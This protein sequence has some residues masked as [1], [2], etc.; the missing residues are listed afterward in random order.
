MLVS[1]EGRRVADTRCGPDSPAQHGTLPHHPAIT[2]LAEKLALG[3]RLWGWGNHT[4]TLEPHRAL[5]YLGSGSL[6]WVGTSESLEPPCHLL[7]S[8][9]HAPG[10][11]V[12]SIGG[13]D[14]CRNPYL[15]KSSPSPSRSQ[16]SQHLLK[17]T[18]ARPCTHPFSWAST[19]LL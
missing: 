6:S 19:L 12:S 5:V 14:R 3:P 11:T 13:T 2:Q 7:P 1:P 16:F 8:D 15:Y 10:G 17:D 18:L 4:I 9:P